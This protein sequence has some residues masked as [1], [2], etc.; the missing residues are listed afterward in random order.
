ML[1]HKF[2]RLKNGKSQT[3]NRRMIVLKVQ[4]KIKLKVII[5]IAP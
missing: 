5:K 3:E 4:V 2:D 1:A